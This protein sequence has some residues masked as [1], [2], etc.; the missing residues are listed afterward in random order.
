MLLDLSI[1]TTAF[2]HGKKGMKRKIAATTSSTTSKQKKAEVLTYRL[3][4]Y[5]L[6][7]ATKLPTAETSKAE[8]V[9]AVEETP[10]AP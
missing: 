4:S 3:K 9:E 6:E 10:S 8:V 5:Y 1:R 7:R 2:P